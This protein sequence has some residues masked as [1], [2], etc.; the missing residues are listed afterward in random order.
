MKRT[1]RDYQRAA[2][3]AFDAALAVNDATMLVLPT[4]TGKTVILGDIVRRWTERTSVLIL[5]HRV[6]LLD[7]AADKFLPEL[8]YRPQVIQADRRVDE[9][10]LSNDNIAVIASVQTL[11]GK[12]GCKRLRMFKDRPFGLVLCDEAHHCSAPS[13]RGIIEQ[14]KYMNPACKVGGVTA[15]PNR[16]DRKALGLIF[17]S[18]AYQMEIGHAVSQGWLVPPCERK[19]IIDGIDFAKIKLTRNEAGEMDFNP[20]ELQARMNE[21]KPLHAVTEP[22]IDMAGERK[23]IVFASGVEHGHRIAEILNR[24]RRGS[25]ESIDGANHPPGHPD[26]KRILNDFCSGDLQFLVNFGICTEGFDA[27][28]CAGICIARPT[29]SLTILIQMIGRGLRPSDG[30]VDRFPDAPT[31]VSAIANDVKPNALILYFIPKTVNVGVLTVVDALG[32]NYDDTERAIARQLT[33]EQP[34]AN[35]LDKL[36]QSMIVA[37]LFRDQR[38]VMRDVE[39]EN[40]KR[41]ALAK[42]IKAKVSYRT[43]DVGRGHTE[44]RSTVEPIRKG[45]ASEKQVAFL[46]DL[47]VEPETAWAYGPKQAYLVTQKLKEK[48]CTNKQRRLL[49][50]FGES[51]DVP[52]ET[53]KR[54]ISLI[55][56]NGWKRRTG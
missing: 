55:A 31:R 53:A 4:G 35:V 6:E 25:A 22:L 17:D 37:E 7:Q 3:D 34:G 1:Q 10:Q 14:C 48:R 32:G 11:N 23:W 28:A 46:I 56:E 29:K 8:G 43:Q 40:A 15:T 27:P 9:L 2:S 12:R 16:T 26:R 21:E 41:E 50:Q 18:V 36:R 51:P 52:Y 39:A 5:A 45:G 30:L 13:W 54:I 47:G 19:V 20:A 38:E 33:D 49:E 24:H 42:A 44:A